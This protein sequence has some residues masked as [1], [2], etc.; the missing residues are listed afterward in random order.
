MVV[1]RWQMCPESTCEDVSC[2]VR[3]NIASNLSPRSSRYPRPRDE[4]STVC[5]GVS[6]SEASQMAVS[7]RCDQEMPSRASSC[8][9]SSLHSPCTLQ[10]R[11]IANNVAFSGSSSQRAIA[12]ETEI[13]SG[14]LL[15]LPNPGACLHTRGNALANVVGY[16]GRNA[17]PPHQ[18]AAINNKQDIYLCTA[19]SGCLVTY[20]LRHEGVVDLRYIGLVS[21]RARRLA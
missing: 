6:H 19:P 8:P 21:H 7:R 3:R 13:R 2:T 10:P 1:K 12:G 15:F 4:R 17:P 16:I 5:A 9:S 14:P 11:M 18:V 20:L